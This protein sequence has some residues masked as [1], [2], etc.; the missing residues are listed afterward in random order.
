MY[1]PSRALVTRFLATFSSQI[2]SGAS[3]VAP[4]R[5][6]ESCNWFNSRYFL[7]RCNRKVRIRSELRGSSEFL[8][9]A[10]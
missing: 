3:V 7:P 5:L 4:V 10:T 1:H 2:N 6:N 9:S 8:L